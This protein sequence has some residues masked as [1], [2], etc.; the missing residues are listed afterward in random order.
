MRAMVLTASGGPEKLRLREMAAPHPAAGQVL[1]DVHYAGMNFADIF[2]R[3]GLY[4]GGPRPPFVPGMELSG[5]VSGAGEGTHL[6]AGD[7]VVALPGAGA[8][9]EQVAVPGKVAIRIPDA[10]PL[11]EAAAF[12]VVYLT[13]Y[14]MLVRIAHLQRG[15]RVLIHTAAGGVGIAA[16]QIAR[17]IGAEIFGTA[18]AS[19]HDFLRQA[20]VAHPI[21]YRT[22][23]FEAEIR[24]IAGKRPL[25]VV[26]DPLGG[27][28]TRKNYR[29]LAPG[30]RLVFFG[31]SRSVT[32]WKRSVAA[33]PEFFRLPR[34]NPLR[35]M[36]DNITVAGFHLGRLSPDLLKPEFDALL[37]LY[38]NAVVKPVIARAF[39]L[40]QL[41]EAHRYIQRR[42]N[43]GKV[44]IS[45]KT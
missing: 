33:L 20:G 35:L 25:D 37:E 16:I 42:E 3:M 43:T 19:K 11:D 40:E 13:A 39:P 2:T 18:S 10:M 17:H 1:I 8:C 30:G 15:E 41:P 9:A 21:D 32:G 31:F 6:K 24:R 44:L 28:A 26:L 45:V 36:A 12:P 4:P 29:L 34:F 27:S 22:A 23:D 5:V 38:R 7:R 14:A